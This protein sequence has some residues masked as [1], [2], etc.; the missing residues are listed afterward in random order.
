MLEPH[1]LTAG[2]PQAKHSLPSHGRISEIQRSAAALK[3]AQSAAHAVHKER[4]LQMPSAG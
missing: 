1:R 3:L 2:G 4:L